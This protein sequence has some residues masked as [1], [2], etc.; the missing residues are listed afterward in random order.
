MCTLLLWQALICA[1]RVRPAAGSSGFRRRN[2]V[3]AFLTAKSGFFYAGGTGLQ[4][5]ENELEGSLPGADLPMKRSSDEGYQ[6]L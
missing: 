5:C 2:A 4:A 3:T 1:G 6:R